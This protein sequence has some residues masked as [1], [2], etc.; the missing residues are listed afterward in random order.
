[1]TLVHF[2]IEM[3]AYPVSHGE[4]KIHSPMIPS[5]PFSVTLLFYYCGSAE[6]IASWK[7]A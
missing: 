2:A 6:S 7:T 1:M 4:S 3:S 5:I